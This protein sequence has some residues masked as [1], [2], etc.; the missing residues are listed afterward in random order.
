[1]EK[2]WLFSLILLLSVL[3]GI[4][5]GMYFRSVQGAAMGIVA[6]IVAAL[7]VG[8][9]WL[10][11][12][13]NSDSYYTYPSE[14]SA[15]VEKVE[16]VTLVIKVPGLPDKLIH[17]ISQEELQAIGECVTDGYV[18]SVQHFKDHFANTKHNGYSLYNKTTRWMQDCGALVPNAKG[19]YDVTEHIGK[20]VF[21]AMRDE[22]WQVLEELEE[23]I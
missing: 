18:F 1:M 2:G 17:G 23:R 19:G 9:K 21:D 4:A 16:R 7:I 5:G 11:P 15:V 13:F 6:G 14:T 12:V 20:H 10:M 8:I 22:A 3:A